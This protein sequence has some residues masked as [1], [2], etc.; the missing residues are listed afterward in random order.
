MRK[1]ASSL[2]QKIEPAQT[3]E[4]TTYNIQK[5]T[6]NYIIFHL[7]H[8]KEQSATITAT[9]LSYRGCRIIT[10]IVYVFLVKKGKKQ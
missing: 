9:Q 1:D 7:L 8:V 4:N 6:S 5:S 3:H 10:G 2:V